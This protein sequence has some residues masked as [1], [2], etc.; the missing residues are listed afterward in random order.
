MC[1]SMVMLRMEDVHVFRRALQFK[2]EGQRKNVRLK[3][4]WNMLRKKS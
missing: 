3:W 2:V 4:M 1:I